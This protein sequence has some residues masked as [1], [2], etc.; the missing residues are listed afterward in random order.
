MLKGYHFVFVGEKGLW[1]P[2][3]ISGGGETWRSRIRGI[4]CELR[5]SALAKDTHLGQGTGWRKEHE[6]GSGHRWHCYGT[7]VVSA[8]EWDEIVSVAKRYVQL[9][10]L[11]SNIS[12]QP[13]AKPRIRVHPQRISCRPLHMST[14]SMWIQLRPLQ[15]RR[16]KV[17]VSSVAMHTPRVMQHQVQE[18]CPTLKLCRIPWRSNFHSCLLWTCITRAEPLFPPTQHPNPHQQKSLW[19]GKRPLRLQRC[20]YLTAFVTIL[21]LLFIFVFNST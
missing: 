2:F 1:I 9:S 16:N 3:W 4:H 12:W 14:C 15:T 17:C 7:L 19:L 6:G 13:H 18:R 5:H 21:R 8:D 10:G 11:N 20:Q